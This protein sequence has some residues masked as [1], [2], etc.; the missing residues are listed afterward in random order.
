MIGVKIYDPNK[1]TREYR[2]LDQRTDLSVRWINPATY[3]PP[4]PRH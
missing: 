3:P 1:G 4:P 2:H